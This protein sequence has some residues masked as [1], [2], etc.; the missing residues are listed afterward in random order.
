MESSTFTRKEPEGGENTLIMLL[1]VYS[2]S[3][4]CNIVSLGMGWTRFVGHMKAVRSRHR[5]VARKPV[6]QKRLGRP[7]YVGNIKVNRDRRHGFD[8]SGSKQVSAAGCIEEGQELD[9]QPQEH[10][11]RAS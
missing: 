11:G 6:W 5:L 9:L 8:S 10:K 1:T 7:R 4:A 3:N 2:S